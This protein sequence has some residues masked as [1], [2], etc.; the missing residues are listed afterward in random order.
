ML[1][2]VPKS[3]KYN[4]R[5]KHL[6]F[7]FLIAVLSSC[8][9]AGGMYNTNKSLGKVAPSGK[10]RNPTMYSRVNPF[11]GR[12]KTKLHKNQKRQRKMIR[13]KQVQSGTFRKSRK[14]G[15]AFGT[16]RSLSRSRMKNS[17]SRSKSGD[18]RGKGNKTLFNTRKR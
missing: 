1:N 7:I 10:Y 17:G 12:A 8:S 15:V 9:S 5:L 6:L 13:R 14:Q 3:H 2:F 16:K 18:G 4:L 11:Q